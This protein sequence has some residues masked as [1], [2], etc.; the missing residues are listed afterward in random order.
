MLEIAAEVLDALAD[1]RRLAVAWV[2]DVLGSAP[3]TAGTAMAVDDRGRVIGSI[4]GG[5]V[6]GAVIEVA[7]GVLDD[8]APALT[9]F[10][11]S[12]DDAF[13][14]GLTCGGR[15]GV[16]VVEVAPAGDA[17]SP[18]PDAVRAALE[19]ARAGRAAS[20]ALVLE[21]PA[22]GT[23]V[24]ADADPV[25]ADP[26]RR[27]RAELA[28]RLAAGRSGTTEVDCA[29]GPMR[30]LH[31]VAA[32]PPR[33]IVF[34][35][36]DFSAALADAAA[37]LGYRV[38]VCDAR[39]AFATRARFPTAH[40]VVAEW[41]DEYLART[42]VDAR[43]VICVLTHD[44]RFDVPLL[45]AALRLPVAFVGAMGSRATDVRRR[46]LLVEEGLTDTELARL[47]SPIGLDIGASTPQET[48]VSILAEVLAARAGTEGAPL[49][50]TTG[51]IHGETA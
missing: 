19:D 43:T 5:C 24:T 41:P 29:D 16:V 35:A 7:T 25:G 3:R 8:G 33:L 23:W 13:Q 46:A 11:V 1:G 51:P 17:R 27:I 47:R 12:D 18:V 4:S 42:E 34:G 26:A 20:L 10:G 44:D 48:A 36:V 38:T 31:L 21:G 28:A 9:S 6:E 30:V 39:P 2:T 49:T 22:V 40:E 37:L 45:V 50:T 32:P 14:V 15:I